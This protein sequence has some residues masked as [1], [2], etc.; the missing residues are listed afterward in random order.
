[1]K[2]DTGVFDSMESAGF[3]ILE[4]FYE[5]EISDP[6]LSELDEE[7]GVEKHGAGGIRFPHLKSRSIARLLDSEKLREL[8][9]SICGGRPILIRSILFD[10]N[11][12]ANWLI[13]WHQDLTIAVREKR[14]TRSFGPWSVKDGVC[15]VHAPQEVLSQILTIRVHLDDC[16]AENGALKVLPG[17]HLL[18]RLKKDQILQLSNESNPVV[19]EV[20]RGGLL[21][22]RPLLVHSSLPSDT[23]VH[24]RVLHLEFTS[25]ELPGGLEW[26]PA[27]SS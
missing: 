14:V 23:P 5:T 18:G 2:T 21:L 15:H 6:F 13:P 16:P 9:A 27:S 3:K 11:D 22:M 25:Q 1:M 17:S 12:N 20:A 19:C 4:S 10:K 24:R 7:L 26:L 8:V